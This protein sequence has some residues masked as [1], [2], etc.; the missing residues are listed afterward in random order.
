MLK[1]PLG[2]ETKW[3]FCLIHSFSA[4]ANWLTEK[5]N[6]RQ[7]HLPPKLEGTGMASAGQSARA[8]DKNARIVKIKSILQS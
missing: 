2:M 4:N 7:G 5:S 6:R 3:P 8:D 1:N